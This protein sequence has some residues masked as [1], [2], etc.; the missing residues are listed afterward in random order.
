MPAS[1]PFVGDTGAVGEIYALG[2]RDPHR[3]SWDS[4]GQHRLYL[5]HIGQH[6]V[7]AVYEV[8][9]GDNLGWSEREGRYVYDPA[10]ECHLYPLPEDDASLGY[11][12]PVASFDHDP[13]PGWPC[14]S[15][16]GHGMSGGLVYRGELSAL[17]GKYVFGDLVDGRVFWSEAGAAEAGAGPRGH[18][19]RDAAVGHR[20]QPAPDARLRG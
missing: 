10:D 2:M 5:G 4:G 15:D 3:F 20:G 13:P 11:V 9:A 16:S 14:S 7:E 19:P 17:E 8:R 18:G 6:A 1:N 12:Y